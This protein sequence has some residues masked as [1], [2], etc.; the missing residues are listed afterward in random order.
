MNNIA[1]HGFNGQPITQLSEDTMISGRLVPKGY[2]NATEMCKA[3]GKHLHKYFQ[4]S[5]TQPFL[6]ALKALQQSRS[7]SQGERESVITIQGGIE[8]E[9]Q[10]TWVS[11]EV[12]VNLAQWISPEFAAW[13]SINLSLI[14]K[15]DFEALT[16]EAEEAKRQLQEIWLK[17][18]QEGKATRRS[19]TDAIKAWYGRNPNGTT[20]PMGLMIAQTTNA[21]YQALWGMDALDIE[22]L[23]NCGRNESRNFM[24]SDCLKVLDRAEA[25]VI[26]FID[27][28]NIKPIDAVP[29]ARI[30]KAKVSLR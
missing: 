29:L 10:G 24:S 28:D 3:N 4:F 6:S 1:L 30:R 20:R 5:K 18:R 7:T 17:V 26:D 16:P 25:N 22:S 8:K 14:I 2:C 21:I 15:G 19:L 27:D 12:A 9:F 11:L 23:L 13:A